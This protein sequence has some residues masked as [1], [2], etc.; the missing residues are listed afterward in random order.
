[1]YKY[2]LKLS[3]ATTIGAGYDVH[4][5]WPYIKKGVDYRH[6]R[7]KMIFTPLGIYRMCKLLEFYWQVNYAHVHIVF[8]TFSC[9]I[10]VGTHL[11]K[12][13]QEKF[14]FLSIY[15]EVAGTHLGQLL[16]YS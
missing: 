2:A 7:L 6:V 3:P 4:Y 14:S 5:R 9:Y 12:Y 8:A 15:I 13:V 1:M 10:L 11:V 16:S